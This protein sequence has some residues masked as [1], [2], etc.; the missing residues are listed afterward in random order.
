MEKRI[1][2]QCKQCG[3][4]LFEV[5]YDDGTWVESTDTFRTK[6]L[7]SCGKCFEDVLKLSES[8]DD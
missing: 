1:I 6:H 4:D 5:N 7:L 2:G 8:L 3:K